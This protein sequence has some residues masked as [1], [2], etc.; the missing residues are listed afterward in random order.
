MFAGVMS[1]WS[2]PRRASPPPP[3]PASARDRPAR[4]PA[5]GLVMPARLA[6]PTSSSTTDPGFAGPASCAT[7]A[8]SPRRSS[9]ATSCRTRRSASGPSGSLRMTVCPGRNS[10]V[11][12]VRSLECTIS[13]RRNGSG[14]D[15][16]P[17]ASI[18]HPQTRP[19]PPPSAYP[20][21]GTCTTTV[22]HKVLFFRTRG[23]SHRSG[24]FDVCSSLP[25]GGCCFGVAHARRSPVERGASWPGAGPGRDGRRHRRAHPRRM[26]APR[27]PARRRPAAPGVHRPGHQHAQQDHHEEGRVR[28]TCSREAEAAWATTV[29]SAVFVNLRPS[30]LSRLPSLATI[31]RH[32]QHSNFE[33]MILVAR[34]KYIHQTRN[35]EG[36]RRPATAVA[37]GTAAS[38]RRS[39]SREGGG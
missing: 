1:R 36:S 32:T 23:W 26:A 22:R 13:A 35:L 3:G 24:E 11:M 27:Q 38:N 25:G 14:P 10:L 12:R 31:K 28:P 29:T 19:P 7:P 30:V 16:A 34:L 20:R 17:R 18:G 39:G 2:T 9:I 5:L 21:L 15:R 33:Q 6:S 37:I 8:T 4:Q